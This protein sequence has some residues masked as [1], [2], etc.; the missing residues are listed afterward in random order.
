MKYSE[1]TFS[2]ID[3]ILNN[4]EE[5]YVNKVPSKLRQ[6]TK[7]NKKNDYITN[8]DSNKALEEQNIQKE[9]KI[10]LAILYL[11]YWCEGEEEKKKLLEKFTEN[12]NIKEAE[13]REKYS[14]ENIYK[15]NISKNVETEQ[16]E[17]S[18]QVYKEAGIF[19]KIWKKIIGF[20]RK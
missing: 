14:V 15:R 1:I 16:Q 13:L 9:T 8:I 19:K 11:N 20:F 4:M 10:L 12:E 5:K 17:N 2:E 18:L 7:D 3:L 6:F